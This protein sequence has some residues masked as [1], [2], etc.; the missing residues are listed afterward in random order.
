MTDS[1]K[2]REDELFWDAVARLP[3]CLIVKTGEGEVIALRLGA[4]VT[5]KQAFL[6]MKQCFETVV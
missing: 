6:R 4:G 2:A 1:L 5:I 3:N